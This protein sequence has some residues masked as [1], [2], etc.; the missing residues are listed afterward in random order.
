M[1]AVTLTIALLLCTAASPTHAHRMHASITTVLFNDRTE[2]I[3]VMH[4]FYLHDAEHAAG[5]LFGRPA[6]LFDSTEDRQR[7]AIHVH[8]GFSLRSPEDAPL[9][10][11]LVGSEIEGDSLWIYQA[12]AYPDIPLTGLTVSQP[13]LQDIWPDQVNTVN[14]ERH[15]TTATLTFRSGDPPRTVVF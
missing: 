10:L 1:R 7:F 14:V 11:Q 15:G 5:E 2:R 12:H 13:A 8:E 4:R 3:E 9:S 6:D